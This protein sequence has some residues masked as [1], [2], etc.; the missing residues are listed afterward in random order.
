MEFPIHYPAST[1]LLLLLTDGKGL[2]AVATIEFAVGRFLSKEEIRARIE[3]FER[4]EMP[5]GFRL[6]TK[7]EAWDYAMKNVT[8]SNMRFAMPGADH[9][10]D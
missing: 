3:E 7:R 5:E 8:G 10:D 9:F 4:D 6:M 2:E 1:D